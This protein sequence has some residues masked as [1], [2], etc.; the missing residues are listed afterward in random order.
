M[1][2]INLRLTNPSK[3][4]CKTHKEVPAVTE[5]TM[6]EKRDTLSFES[7]IATLPGK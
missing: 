7:R 2:V 4:P 3:N 6:L 5:S 1:Y